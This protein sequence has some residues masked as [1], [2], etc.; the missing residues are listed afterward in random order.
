MTT[1]AP[2]ASRSLTLELGYGQRPPHLVYRAVQAIVGSRPGG[3]LC[4]H[5]LRRVDHGI[6]RVSGG[7]LILSSIVAGLPIVE[8]TTTGARTGRIRSAFVLAI[9]FGDDIAVAGANFASGTQP[10][11]VANLL[12]DPKAMVGCHT[13]HVPV[14]ARPA[15][16]AEFRQ[17]VTAATRVFPPWAGYPARI[18]DRSLRAFVLTRR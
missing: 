16:D 18:H 10:G 11:W 3:W 4:A 15:T 14:V 7:R 5:V 12:A 2:E 13:H 1:V 17:I 9:P 8:L 6:Q